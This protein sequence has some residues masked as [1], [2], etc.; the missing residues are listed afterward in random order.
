M[1]ELIF[2]VI[3]IGILAAISIPKIIV[4]RDDAIIAKTKTQ[5]S[6]IQ[7]SVLNIYATNILSGNFEYP[8]LNKDN[9]DKLFGNVLQSG[10]LPSASDK[11]GWVGSGENKFKFYLGK[12]STIFAY[13]ISK[14]SFECDIKDELCKILTQ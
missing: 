8:K 2:V 12:R 7:S 5:I 4:T 14:G 6:A 10:V 9:D 11:Y 13:D 1:I 3:I